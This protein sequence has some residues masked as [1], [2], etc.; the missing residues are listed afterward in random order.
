VCPSPRPLS[1]PADSYIGGQYLDYHMKGNLPNVK[2]TD[3]KEN[4]IFLKYKEIQMGSGA[5]S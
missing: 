2:F 4:E 5:K 3:K 1:P